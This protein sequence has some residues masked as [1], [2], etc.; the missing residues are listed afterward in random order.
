M[1]GCILGMADIVAALIGKLSLGKISTKTMLIL[2]YLIAGVSG[3][4]HLMSHEE[5]KMYGL[6]IFLMWIGIVISY[7]YSYYANVEY[8]PADFA[9]SVFGA[10][11]FAARILTIVAPL[12][13]ELIGKP[14]ILLVGFSFFLVI[15][16]QGL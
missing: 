10:S 12:A 4:L 11:N 14:I 15:I 2:G 8:F 3:V 9:T 6:T 13:V 7:F 16:L 1:N 5:A